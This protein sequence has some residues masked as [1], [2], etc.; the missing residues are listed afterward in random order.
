MKSKLTTGL[1]VLGLALAGCGKKAGPDADH[2]GHGAAHHEH[3]APHGGTLVEVGE[4]QFNL[5]FLHDP[6]A[7]KLTLWVLDAHAE[8]FVRIPMRT[9]QVIA[10]DGAVG[11]TV[12]LAAVANPATGE[13]V[14][15][16]SQFEGTAPWLQDAKTAPVRL[17]SIEIRGVAFRDVEVTLGVAGPASDHDHDERAK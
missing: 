8:N 14:G 6:A 7:G 9:I 17:P 1:V 4:H 10:G 11:Q 3:A 13:T 5:E 2:A 15:D 16:T 12:S